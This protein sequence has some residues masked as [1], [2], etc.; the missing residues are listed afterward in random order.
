MDIEEVKS[1]WREYV[2]ELYHDERPEVSEI[3]IEDEEG[4]TIMREEVRSAME[5]MKTGKALG[6][7]GIAVEVLRALRDF[8]VDQLTITISAN[9]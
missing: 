3:L 5:S 6:G 2:G 1:R 4:P 9:I 8:A 7:D